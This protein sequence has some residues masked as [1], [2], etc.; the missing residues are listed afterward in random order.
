MKRDN[1]YFEANKNA[2]NSKTP[3]HIGSEFYD[4]KNFKKGQTSLKFIELEELG[5]V[6]GKSI[7]H[8]QCHFGMD[9]LS[10]ARMGA[11]VTG[12]DISDKAI[13]EAKKLNDELNLD[14]EF[15]CCNIFDLPKIIN[16]K[17]DIVFTSYGVIGWLPELN[18][19]GKIISH[20]LNP[21][22]IF[23]MVEF[24]PFIWMFDDEFKF[25]QYSYFMTEPIKETYSGT[26]ADK[27]ADIQNTS[28]GWNHTF[29]EILNSLIKQGLEIK[30]LNEFPFSTY[31]CFSNM[32]KIGVDK[33]VFE[34]H[35]DIIPYLY[36]IKAIKK[37]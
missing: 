3:V 23:Y 17:F 35:K 31:N 28:Y 6:K 25:F 36:S 21:N 14:A 1:F 37:T 4:V 9:S 8:L 22:G 15:V 12:I 30:F 29:S 13:E 16:K 5:D 10:L 7:L 32:E 18:E 11:K 34:N 33:Y 24:H 27:N 19:W 2:W 26:Y 20:F